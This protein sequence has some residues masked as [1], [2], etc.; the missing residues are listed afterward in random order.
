MSARHRIA[1]WRTR[2]ARF[3]WSRG[4]RARLVLPRDARGRLLNRRQRLARRWRIWRGRA[5]GIIRLRRQVPLRRRVMARV[6]RLRPRN[7][8]WPGRR[9][10]R[11]PRS[12]A[13][14]FAP[15]GLAHWLALR[16]D[17]YR[18]GRWHRR[19]GRGSPRTAPGTRRPGDPVPGRR[20]TPNGSGTGPGRTAG[21]RP[22]STQV[23]NAADE[24]AQLGAWD[25]EGPADLHETIASLDTVANSVASA[26]EQVAA[27]LEDYGVNSGFSET[28]R[29]QIG[30]IRSASASLHETAGSGLMERAGGGDG[31]SSPQVRSVVDTIGDL[32]HW[33]PSDPDE[34]HN[35]IRELSVISDSVGTSYQQLSDTISGTGAHESYPPALDEAAEVM[36]A[37]GRELESAFSEGVMRNPRRGGG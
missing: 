13:D 29:E 17:R 14:R 34:L 19:H 26:Y 18:Y 7:W 16:A 22:V 6:A 3:R 4:W 9:R 10:R 36:S 35:T 32:G 2:W 24:V 25:P 30:S 28:L 27:T 12:W 33:N 1:A 5:P 31:A 8:R 21:G 20:G 23:E 15:G 37:A 11:P